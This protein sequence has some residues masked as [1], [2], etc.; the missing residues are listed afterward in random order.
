[1]KPEWL[2]PGR[3][4]QPADTAS[5]RAMGGGNQETVSGLNGLGNA[6]NTFAG[7]LYRSNG[8]ITLTLTGLPTHTGLNLGF[9]F[10]AIDSWDG[11]AGFNCCG[12][13]TFQVRVNSNTVFS[14]TF[15]IFGH[16]AG[17]YNAPTN[18]LITYGSN[19]IGT[20]WGDQ[21][22]DMAL[23]AAFQNIADSSSSL[24]ISWTQLNSQGYDDESFALDNVRIELLGVQTTPPGQN[25]PEPGALA[26]LG[27]G[28]GA[29]ANVRRRRRS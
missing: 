21:A 22:Y 10:A 17:D 29:L 28:L 9:L 12:P 5:N 15:N 1:M 20:G 24:T 16:A 4:G 8:T 14:Q 25:V 6:G 23:E 27:I 7:N 11:P 3:L 13:D 18:G 26:L 2:R 19:L